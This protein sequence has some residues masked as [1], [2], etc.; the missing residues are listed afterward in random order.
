MPRVTRKMEMTL[1]SDFTQTRT[2]FGRFLMYLLNQQTKALRV[3]FQE[4]K[5]HK[6]GSGVKL[7]TAFIMS[8]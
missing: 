2:I 8:A 1:R 3:S 5:K 4:E 7:R 6:L